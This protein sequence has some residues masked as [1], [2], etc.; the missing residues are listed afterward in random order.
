MSSQELA[1][2]SFASFFN[3]S[4]IA[5]RDLQHTNLSMAADAALINNAIL[6]AHAF[7]VSVANL[8]WR[9]PQYGMVGT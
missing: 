9:W 4:T 2:L 1:Y 8:W 3:L 5:M 7:A 6:V